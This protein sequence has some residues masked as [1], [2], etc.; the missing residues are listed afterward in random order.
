MKANPI[1]LYPT[2]VQSVAS[3]HPELLPDHI[4]HTSVRSR[5]SC[6]IGATMLVY[7]SE[8][9]GLVILHEQPSASQEVICPW[10]NGTYKG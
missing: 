9:T 6:A 3:I 10:A 5:T 8:N 1:G 7:R 4:S 2:F